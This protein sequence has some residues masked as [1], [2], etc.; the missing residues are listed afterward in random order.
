MA[1]ARIKSS[2][3][4][5]GNSDDNTLTETINGW[6]N[7]QRLLRLIRYI[8]PPKLKKIAIRNSFVKRQ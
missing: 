1:E 6:F 7:H 3:G 4:I 8:S 2:V 5:Q